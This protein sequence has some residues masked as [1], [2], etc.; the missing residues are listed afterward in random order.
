MS[1]RL[2]SIR[3]SAPA[4]CLLS[5]LILTVAPADSQQP[6]P[7]QTPSSSASAT[8]ASQTGSAAALPTLPP[9]STEPDYP[10]PRTITLGVFGLS[11]LKY[12]GPSIRGGNVA[13]TDN[14]YED[15]F[16][17]GQPYRAIPQY[18]FSLPITRTGTLYAEFQ[19]YHGWADQTLGGPTYVD[20]Y[21]FVSGDTMHTTYHIITGRIYLDDLMFPHKF[22]VSRL[23]FKSIWGIRY[24]SVTQTV[25]SSTEDATQGLSGASFNLGTNYIMFPEFGIA[26]EYAI[27]PHV[28]FRVD[29]AGFGFP[30]HADMYDAGASLSFRRKNLEILA[31]VKD[32]H[33]KTTPQKEE[34][35]TGTFITPFIG[36]RWHL[37]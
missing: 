26:P 4:V 28:L 14:Y 31:G 19:R 35:V 17:I 3:V 1:I 29:A 25:D 36:I 27:T 16:N 32:L 33:F 23:R 12:A 34:Y 22:P 30:H 11:N 13:A 7:S 37:Q 5:A 8:G 15:L 2:L 18:E 21:N 24:I 6:A 10:D 20:S 9:A